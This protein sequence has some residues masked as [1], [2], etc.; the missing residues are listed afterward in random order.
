MNK[1][2]Y[3]KAATTAFTSLVAANSAPG[4]IQYYDDS[5][6]YNVGFGNSASI[7]WNIDGEGGSEASW[8]VANGGGYL[9]LNGYPT[10][11]A[12]N[13]VIQNQTTN[14]IVDASAN[15]APFYN[16]G[17]IVSSDFNNINGFTSGEAGY[18]GFRFEDGGMTVYGWAEATFFDKTNPSPS[19]V[20]VTV[21][22]WAYQD[23]GSG[24]RVGNTGAI[25]EPAAVATGLGALALGAAGLRRWRKQ[26][27]AA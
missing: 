18:F 27:Q 26:K 13:T 8:E 17:I 22:Q 6:E 3:H 24:I 9:G 21:H 16:S 10:F 23:D 14:Y 1:K 12:I 25:P 2:H 15:F 20:G 5:N 4:I 7:D 19:G 11:F